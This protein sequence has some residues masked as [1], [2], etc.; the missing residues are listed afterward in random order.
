MK[1][2]PDAESDPLTQSLMK[3]SERMIRESWDDMEA[4]DRLGVLIMYAAALS[5][6]YL[7]HRCHMP[8]ENVVE[9]G[10]RNQFMPW[11]DYD[12]VRAKLI[13][14]PEECHKMIYGKSRQH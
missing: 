7:E 13:N 9:I 10:Q 2:D 14:N 8:I 5:G 4:H 3:F 11:T 12:A 1:I 6:W